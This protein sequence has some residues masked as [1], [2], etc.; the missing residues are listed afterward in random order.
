MEATLVVMALLASLAINLVLAATLAL[1]V[2]QRG[3]L[4]DRAATAA[5]SLPATPAAHGGS[6]REVIL[7]LARQGLAAEAIAQA[8]GLSSGEVRLV[9]HLN[10]MAESRLPATRRVAAA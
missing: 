6:R 5:A 7:D 3:G 4:R 2:K 9:L 1:A 10:A 8:C